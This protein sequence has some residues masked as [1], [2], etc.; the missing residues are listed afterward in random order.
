MV[1]TSSS[2]TKDKKRKA[3]ESSG[4]FLLR[5]SA[6][7]GVEEYFASPEAARRLE[8]LARR[9]PAEGEE[10]LEPLQIILSVPRSGRALIKGVVI[11]GEKVYD[12]T[13]W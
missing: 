12:Q 11:D 10:A 5:V 13:I 8:E 7:Y 3:P 9:R 2:P 4:A 1:Q 6:Q